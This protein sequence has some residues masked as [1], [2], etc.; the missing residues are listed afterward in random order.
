[1]ERRPNKWCPICEQP[2]WGRNCSNCGYSDN[3][4]NFQN[5][6]ISRIESSIERLGGAISSHVDRLEANRTPPHLSLDSE[7]TFI[8][9]GTMNHKNFIMVQGIARNVQRWEQHEG[10]GQ[11]LMPIK[12]LAFTVEV[13]DK[14]GDIQRY[15]PVYREAHRI[16]GVL[17]SGDKVSVSGNIDENGTLIPEKIENQTTDAK[18]AFQASTDLSD[19][20]AWLQA[21]I[22]F[23]AFM[24]VLSVGIWFVQETGFLGAVIILIVLSVV[25]FAYSA[26]RRNRE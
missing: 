17:S 18:I 15:V 6:F 9:R 14:N 8:T 19:P 20:L 24:T 1:M 5:K 13:T 25:Y 22:F 4:E 12:V 23:V 2:L 7:E 26:Y 3:T 10:M 16:Q 21:I 11:T